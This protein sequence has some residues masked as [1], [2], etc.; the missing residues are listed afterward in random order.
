VAGTSVKGIGNALPRASRCDTPAR[1]GLLP[2]GTWQDW[3]RK[4]LARTGGNLEQYKHPCLI[5]DPKFRD[6]VPVE[7]ELAVARA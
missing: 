3:D 2:S 1:L 6:S 7:E 5:A 4:R